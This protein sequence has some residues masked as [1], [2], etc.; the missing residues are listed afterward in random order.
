MSLAYLIDFLIVFILI[1]AIFYS[2]R[3]H[4]KLTDLYQT[5][6]DMQSFLEGFTNSLNRAEISMQALKNTGENTFSAVNEALSKGNALRDDLLYLL[7][8]GESIA[9]QL[10]DAIRSARALQKDIEISKNISSNI[11]HIKIQPTVHIESE[12][13]VTSAQ[14]DLINKLRNVR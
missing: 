10:D 4:N 6:G 12:E 8:R 14:S 1:G 7:D 5:R 2:V 11:S 3:L 9:S 13:Q